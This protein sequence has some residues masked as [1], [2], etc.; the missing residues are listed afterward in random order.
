M[1]PITTDDVFDLMDGYITSAAL[2]S[3]LE[4][5]LFWLLEPHPQ[6]A[7]SVARALDIPVGRCR[8]WLQLLTTLGL[9]DQGPQGYGPS[10]AARAAII[11]ACSQDTWVLLAQDA[12]DRFPAVL[13]L[14]RHIHEPGSVWVAQGLAPPDYFVQMVESPE[15]ARRFTRML[16]ELHAPLAEA[17]A[18]SLDLTGVDRLMDLGGGSGVMSLALLR[19][20]PRLTAVV[21]DVATV[22]AAGREIARDLAESSLEERISYHAAN[23]VHDE[24]PSGFDLIL[25]CDVGG[26]SETLLGKLWTALNSGGRL[27]I[28]DHF[29]PAQGLAPATPP[30]PH[31]AFLGSLHTPDASR[32]T[33][34]E[35]KTR[36]AGAG[37]RRLSEEI[38]P[39]RG[40]LRW[41]KDWVVLEAS[42]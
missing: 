4:L 37:F 30:Y 29:A 32:P 40:T 33:A 15:R 38:L 19:R 16:Y 9:L 41:T 22:C 28:V 23:F 17:L 10:T 42:K 27:V 20:Y 7:P 5:G 34:T 18:G 13:D 24:L 39:Q 11:D 26:Y 21:V 12:R 8:H 2:N 14:A 35:I 1:G 31:W 25:E 36:L 6:D 3:A